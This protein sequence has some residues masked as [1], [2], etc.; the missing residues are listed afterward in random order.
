MALYA[1]TKNFLATAIHPFDCR[2]WL[3]DFIQRDNMVLCFGDYQIRSWREEDAPVLSKH[4]NNR[5][6]WANLRD[7]FPHPYRLSDAVRFITMALNQDPECFF[8]VATPR[9]AIGGIGLALG[10]DIHR[11]TAELGYWLAEPLWNKG[12]M[13]QAVGAF[14]PWAFD[15]FKLHRIFAEPYAANKAS[16]R[17]LEKNGFELEGT[18]RANVFKNDSIQDQLLYAKIRQEN[19]YERAHQMVPPV[20]GSN[21]IQG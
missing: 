12:I 11:Y 1:I 7:L 6:I 9:E 21:K 17:I 13:T 10:R 3:G 18:L 14:V 16:A 20:L 8:A 2:V 19:K 15:R 4:A 5:K